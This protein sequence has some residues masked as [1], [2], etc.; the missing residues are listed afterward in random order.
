ML[1]LVINSNILLHY[2]RRFITMVN[3]LHKY[4]VRHFPLPKIHLKQTTFVKFEI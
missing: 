1:L 3:L 2:P 4:Y